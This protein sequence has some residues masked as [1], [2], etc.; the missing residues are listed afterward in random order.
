MSA[1][2]HRLIRFVF[3]KTEG[4]PDKE[5]DS[6]MRQRMDARWPNQVFA[7]FRGTCVRT[8]LSLLSLG[9]S[10]H[11][12]TACSIGEFLHGCI[13]Y[14][15]L[16]AQGCR[17]DETCRHQRGMLSPHDQSSPPPWAPTC[18]DSG[19]GATV[20]KRTLS[21]VLI[22]AFHSGDRNEITPVRSH[23]EFT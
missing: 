12:T 11:H 8:W 16:L 19:T 6:V 10:G 15:T 13:P 18:V 21:Q 3:G 23:L 5:I 14:G 4:P 7:F 17:L 22:S 20:N 9:S 2:H 1:R